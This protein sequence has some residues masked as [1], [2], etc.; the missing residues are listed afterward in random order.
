MWLR[1]ILRW[2]WLYKGKSG[3]GGFQKNEEQVLPI[4]VVW[5]IFYPAIQFWGVRVIM[6]WRIKVHPRSSLKNKIKA[7]CLKQL[8]VFISN[9]NGP[10]Q[11]SF[12]NWLLKLKRKTGPKYNPRDP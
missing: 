9:K 6:S 11:L 4:T 7:P 1:H 10:I 3:V 8:P 2:E 5:I 12:L